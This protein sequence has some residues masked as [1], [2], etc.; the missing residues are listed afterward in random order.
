MACARM[1]VAAGAHRR[2]LRSLNGWG[3]GKGAAPAHALRGE[4]TG[5]VGMALPLYIERCMPPVQ[6]DID[7]MEAAPRDM[8]AALEV[9]KRQADD[10]WNARVA[11]RR[12]S[13]RLRYALELEI[14]RR[15]RERF[16]RTS[17]T[18]G[19]RADLA[20]AQAAGRPSGGADGGPM[21]VAQAKAVAMAGRSGAC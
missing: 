3:K 11:C 21:A 12:A 2:K 5:W 17:A 4:R 15:M 16:V 1:H 14:L 6:A 20:A 8:R 9:L 10:H 7:A 13:D 19:E 18:V